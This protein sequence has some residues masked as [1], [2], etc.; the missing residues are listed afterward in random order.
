MLKKLVFLFLISFLMPFVARAEN[1]I[2][3]NYEVNLK[4][5]K[6][7][8]ATVVEN[9][10]VFF[11]TPSHGI[12]RK[13]PV[14]S[15][16]RVFL[17]YVSEDYQTSYE[18]G[19][20]VIKMG[21]PQQLISGE[22]D[23]TIVY[24]HTMPKKPKEFYYNLIGTD[25]PV[26]IEK[27]SFMVEFPEKVEAEKVGLSI[28]AYGTRGFS[29][30]AEYGVENNRVFG[31]TE[32]TL[33]PY[34][35][36]TL[37]VEVP[38]GYFV[39]PKDNM[40][41]YAAIGLAFFTII[42][43]VIW[44]F[45]GKDEK[46]ILVVNFYPPKNFNSAEFEVLYQ[47]KASS[48]GL[49]AL[50]FYLAD[51]GYLKIEQKGKDFVLY[52]IKDYDGIDKKIADFMTA[53]FEEGEQVSLEKLQ[54][55]EDFYKECKKAIKS[56]NRL[57]PNIFH[58]NSIG[59]F[60][61]FILGLAIVGIIGINLCIMTGFDASVLKFYSVL[62]IFP[63]TA[64]VVWV[65]NYKKSFWNYTIWAIVYGGIPIFQM[66]S[67]TSFEFLKEKWY[68]CLMLFG[69]GCLCISAV[70][71][72]QLPKRNK[73]GRRVLGEIEGFKKFLETAEAPRVK[74]LAEQDQNYASHILPYLYL[75]GLSAT[76]ISKFSSLF[77]QK[78]VWFDG[79]FSSHS[80]ERFSSGMEKS[81]VPT[82]KNGGISRSSGGGGFSGGGCGGGGGGSW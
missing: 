8:T 72:Y 43:V 10:K 1:F 57:R 4:V 69:L 75:F 11:H 64:I 47:G 79:N 22:H 44:F 51:A 7:K 32:E 17:D 77:A 2:I 70:C 18:N 25:W 82:V 50:I 80:F 14:R 29:G 38:E 39:L 41:L 30:G 31:H 58:E 16:E 15:K 9:I 34:E 36:V 54:R 3:K 78:L 62:A 55:S 40:P 45:I 35:G 66:L 53:L 24:V 76:W 23:Y 61:R 33:G 37:R 27:A 28:G 59:L 49:V 81:V 68:A 20:Y 52:K 19:N 48:K 63:A 71:L 21:D 5:E 13:I 65:L 12:F 6:D 60:Y 42:C 67:E 73:F 26:D 56:F 46:V 74:A